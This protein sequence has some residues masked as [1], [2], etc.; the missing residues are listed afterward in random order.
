MATVTEPT[1]SKIRETASILIDGASWAD[2]EAMRRIIG[3]RHIFVNYDQGM[4]EVLVPSYSHED[5]KDCLRS[6]VDI[7]GEEAGIP[8]QNGGSTTHRREDLEKGV[9]PDECYWLGAKAELMVGVRELDLSIDP[10]PSLVIEVNYTHSSVS[11]MAIYASLRVEEVW[12][13]DNG[14]SF[15]SPG[16]DGTYEPVNPSRQLPLLSVEEAM[17]QLSAYRSMGRLDWMRAFRRH[18]REYLVPH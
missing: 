4:L 18:V 9:E 5:L 7:L 15:L 10:A 11:R 17:R 12:R 1:A 2:Y 3:D 8:M 6:M 16:E 13:Y 14:L